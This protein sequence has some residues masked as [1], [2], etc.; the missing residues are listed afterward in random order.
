MEMVLKHYS[1]EVMRDERSA[2]DV[3]PLANQNVT[4]AKI[5]LRDLVIGGSHLIELSE[6][7]SIP[8]DV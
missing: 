1:G 2:P 8:V 6:L 3:A 5:K 4:C 7:K